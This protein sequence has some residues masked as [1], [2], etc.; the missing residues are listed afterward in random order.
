[1]MYEKEMLAFLNIPKVPKKEWDGKTPFKNG[2]GIAETKVGDTF[3]VVGYTDDCDNKLK[4]LKVFGLEPIIGITKVYP[5]PD[6]MD[7]KGIDEWD[8]DEESKKAA[9]NL[10]EEIN[11]MEHENVEKQEEYKEWYFDEIHDIEEARAWVASYRKRNRMKGQ[12]PQSEEALKNY[13]YVI[14]KNK[15][16]GIE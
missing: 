2:V 6:Y 14:Y 5:V 16:R 4:I 7:L 8:I 9:H 1:M 12:M 3:V 13:L 11:E 15:K 10:V